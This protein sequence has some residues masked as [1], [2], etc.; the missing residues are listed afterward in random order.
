[1][2][3][4]N[5]ILELLNQQHGKEMFVDPDKK[6][7]NLQEAVERLERMHKRWPGKKRVNA[8]S[9]MEVGYNQAIDDVITTLKKLG[10]QDV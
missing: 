2:T 7:I 6:T 5:K 1:M 3:D 8:H 4:P 10:G 9:L